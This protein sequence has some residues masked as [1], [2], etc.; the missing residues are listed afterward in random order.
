MSTI[1]TAR[2]VTGA[3]ALLLACGPGDK[4]G[5]LLD[6]SSHTDDPT[7]TAL[8][9]WYPDDD[10]DGYGDA[11]AGG[12]DAVEAPDGF[13]ASH[14]DCDDDDPAVHPGAAEYCN[15][16]DDDCDDVVD[17]ADSEDALT[18][19][20]DADG[21]GYGSEGDTS[22][23]CDLPEGY[24]AVSGDC[25]DNTAEV[26]PS[27][28]EVCNSLDDDCDGLTDGSD[29]ISTWY[30]DA[31]GDGYGADDTSISGEGCDVPAG[32]VVT[33]GDCDDDDP[34]ISPEAVETCDNDVDEDCTGDA[35]DCTFWGEHELSDSYAVF[36]GDDGVRYT[37][38]DL[39]GGDADGDGLADLWIGSPYGDG[40]SDSGALFLISSPEAG[41]A[42][43]Q[44]AADATLTAATVEKEV[45]GHAN[46][47][48][49]D[50]D[51]YEDLWAAVH[52]GPSPDWLCLVLAPIRGTLLVDEEADL[53]WEA[54]SEDDFTF[55][56]AVDA[57]KDLDGDGMT[58]AVSGDGSHDG[59]AG[60]VAVLLTAEL[61]G[62]HDMADVPVFISG[63][64]EEWLGNDIALVSD[65]NGDGAADMVV[66]A[67]N[68]SESALLAGAAYVLDD[69]PVDGS[70]VVD[71]VT[72]VLTGVAKEDLAGDKVAGVGDLNDDGYGDFAVGARGASRS[73]VSGGE[74]YVFFGPVGTR[75][76]LGEANA[77][78]YGHVAGLNASPVDGDEDVD[79]DGLPDL[80]IG[81]WG[82]M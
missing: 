37:G 49:I 14:D 4:P 6:E 44:D 80:L 58:D 78:V 40:R 39:A 46:A 48:D 13:V 31:D 18:W 55:S 76:S 19:F 7:D 30:R 27:A 26:H 8:T 60:G 45:L 34:A 69:L 22:V 70:Y 36:R 59:Y 12:I 67:Q 35:R 5:E 64:E 32:Y 68:N 2:P 56:I 82:Q 61:T 9:W 16:R 24:A 3:L 63:S 73:V 57:G 50:G 77:I 25:D 28:A 52:S 15:D 43:V 20:R 38:W 41:S 42:S 62:D 47:G 79:G 10:R 66:G 71:D 65:S 72:H 1:A 21:D 54:Q 75:S 29:A 23:A 81:A 33:D 74:A 51:G 53:R 11:D 17:E